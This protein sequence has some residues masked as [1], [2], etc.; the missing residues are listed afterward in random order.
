MND[1]QLL[2]RREMARRVLYTL[3]MKK[4]ARTKRLLVSTEK[5]RDLRPQDLS[6]TT[7][8]GHGGGC[9]SSDP[10]D[11]LCAKSLPGG[12]AHSYGL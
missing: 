2:R 4:P 7:G 12:C 8:G 3:T 10:Q 6:A 1:L 9:G 11:P 5:V